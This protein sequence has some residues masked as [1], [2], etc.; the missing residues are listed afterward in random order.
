MQKANIKS[1]P[2]SQKSQVGS[3]PGHGIPQKKN[4]A[5]PVCML[6]VARSFWILQ[7]LS[8]EG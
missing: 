1:R 8:V 2:P 3:G 7:L 4:P 5:F 6:T